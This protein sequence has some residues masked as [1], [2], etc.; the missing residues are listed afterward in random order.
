MK[1]SDEQ[2]NDSFEQNNPNTK[3][4]KRNRAAGIKVLIPVC[5]TCCVALL[6]LGIWKSGL[7]RRNPGTNNT[8]GKAGQATVTP[9]ETITTPTPTDT[10]TTPT[11]TVSTAT[12]TPTPTEI[13]V[14]L[15][16][17]QELTAGSAGEPADIRKMD[18]T[19]RTAY[20]TFAYKLFA[21]LP[22]GESRMISPFSVYVALSMLAN[23]ADGE[24][25]A[26]LDELLGLTAEERNAYLAGWLGELEAFRDS[27]DT[28]L[29]NANSVWIH[30]GLESEVHKDFL[31]ICAQYFKAGFFSAPMDDST[32]RDVN[33]WVKA[34]TRNMS[35]Q[36]L[37]KVSPLTATILLNAIT[38]DAKWQEEFDDTLTRDA[39]F[40]KADGT[41]VTVDMMEGDVADGYLE[42]MLATGFIKTY[43]G[44]AF[45]YIALVPKRD[46]EEVSLDQLLASLSPESIRSLIDNKY[47]ETCVVYM[48]KYESDYGL[49]LVDVLKELGVTDVFDEKADLSRMI[50]EP[51]DDI[52]VSSVIHKTHISVD[53]KGTQAA[54]STAV[55]SEWKSGPPC[56]ILDRPFVY[57]IVDSEGLPIFIG[58]Y[59][60]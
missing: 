35:D 13:P 49:N 3:D 19:M 52:C 1:S 10:N 24:T 2:T 18:D 40:Y 14:E 5:A 16:K 27:S 6:V 32:V 42:N 55:I 11:P 51:E 4:N 29:A 56:V 20:E 21:Q 39:F 12:P 37:K 44:G 17:A 46:V 45:S 30:E 50:G 54:A 9:G 59:E 25:L 41:T 57:M 58:T 38:F 60:G 47:D 22:K 15:E 7:L 48:P 8:D 23:G 26:Q 28:L 43:K 31:D 33:G 53:A 36:L 34:K